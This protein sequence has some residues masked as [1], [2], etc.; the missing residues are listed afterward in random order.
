MKSVFVTSAVLFFACEGVLVIASAVAQEQTEMDIA[1]YACKDVMRDP[2]HEVAIAFLPG[3]LPG[4]TNATKF[5]VEAIGKQTGFQIRPTRWS[6][7]RAVCAVRPT[8]SSRMNARESRSATMSIVSWESSPP[9]E[10]SNSGGRG[11]SWS[12][13]PPSHHSRGSDVLA[14]APQQLGLE[15]YATRTSLSDR[16]KVR[17]VVLFASNIDVDVASSKIFAAAS[18]PDLPYG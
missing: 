8:S 15:A 5:D 16:L 18:D 3:Y 2:N 12:A 10:E 14:S 7:L 4:K 1:K 11:N 9:A 13:R 17:N 6:R